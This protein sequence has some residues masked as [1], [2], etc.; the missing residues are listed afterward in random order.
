MC[1]WSDHTDYGNCNF[2]RKVKLTT[3]KEIAEVQD[4][5]A[6]SRGV[7]NVLITNIVLLDSRCIVK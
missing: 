2:E 4:G 3:A 6:K 5:I 1:R 7:D